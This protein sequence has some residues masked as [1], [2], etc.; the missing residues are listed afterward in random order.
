MTRY[1]EYV[2]ELLYAT[3]NLQYQSRNKCQSNSWNLRIQFN[4]TIYNLQKPFQAFQARL[5]WPY[6]F[7]F[8]SVQVTGVYEYEVNVSASFKFQV[9]NRNWTSI[10]LS[11]FLYFHSSQNFPEIVQVRTLY[12]EFEQLSRVDKEIP[13]D[14]VDNSPPASMKSDNHSR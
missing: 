14:K 9:L 7:L 4:C 1:V 5:H 11:I 13:I 12:E 8:V 2:H 10:K 3:K 6:Y